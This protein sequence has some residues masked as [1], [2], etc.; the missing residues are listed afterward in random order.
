MGGFGMRFLSFW[1][2]KLGY[3][4]LWLLF[5]FFGVPH[6]G[7]TAVPVALTVVFLRGVCLFG[8][9]LAGARLAVKRRAIL[10]VRLGASGTSNDI[11]LTEPSPCEGVIAGRH[12]PREVRAALAVLLLFLVWEQN[13]QC[14]PLVAQAY[15]LLWFACSL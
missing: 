11:P 8:R 6:G 9:T 15:A 10:P 12:S 7:R 5:S 13:T 4:A 1:F 2:N 14:R 3:A